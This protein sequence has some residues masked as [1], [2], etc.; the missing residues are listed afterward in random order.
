MR[1]RPKMNRPMIDTSDVAGE[2]NTGIDLASTKTT[3]QIHQTLEDINLAIV[4]DES[5]KSPSVDKYAKDLAFMEQKVTFVVA[6]G[7]KEEAPVITLGVNGQ[8]VNV[9]RGQPI[10]C[11]R[12]FLNTLFTFVHEMATDHYQDKDGLT[13]TRLVKRQVPAFQTS[14]MEDTPEGR[15]W[16]AQQQRQYY[17]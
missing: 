9:V 16:F 2:V 8:N 14:I 6:P 12:K 3:E 10:R 4:T 15:S 17:V 1:G 13:Q 11:A 5:L 7:T